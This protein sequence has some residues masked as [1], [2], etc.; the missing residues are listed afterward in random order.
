MSGRL[1]LRADGQVIGGPTVRTTPGVEW[2]DP[3]G[4]Q[5]VG[6]EWVVYKDKNTG[7]ARLN[8]KILL[9]HQKQHQLE[10][11]GVVMTVDTRDEETGAVDLVPQV[12]GGVTKRNG[13]GETEAGEGD[14]SMMKVKTGEDK[15]VAIVGSQRKRLW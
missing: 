1:I 11:D 7:R 12:F 3:E 2:S 15:L 10:M 9:S 13:D 6:G 4:L 14:F 5:P 8:V